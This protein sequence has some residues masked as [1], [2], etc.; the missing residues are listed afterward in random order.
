MSSLKETAARACESIAG[1]IDALAPERR[2]A[3]L[4]WLGRGEVS[5]RLGPDEIVESR[6]PGIWL[7]AESIRIAPVPPRLLEALGSYREGPPHVPVPAGVVNGPAV[8]AEILGVSDAWRAEPGAPASGTSPLPSRIDLSRLPLSHS[9]IGYLEQAVGSSGV[10]I[11]VS[12]D[13]ETR[14]TATRLPGIWWGRYYE[15]EGRETLVTIEVGQVPELVGVSADDLA[16]SAAELSEWLA[17]E[18]GVDA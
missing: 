13:G 4:G 16:A 14:F 1:Q 6:L 11:T 3:L 2:E 10:E 8:L 15:P 9:D 17:R 18:A 5:L 7:E 12:C